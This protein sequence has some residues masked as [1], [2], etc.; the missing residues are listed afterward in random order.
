M[1]IALRSGGFPYSEFTY[2]H[3]HFA[4]FVDLKPENV[5]ICIDDVESIIKA[6]LAASSS[7]SPPTKLVG[8][9]PSKG[10]G[11][12]QTPRSESVSIHSSQPLPS[13]SSSFGSSPMLDKWAFSM[14]KI[15]G[16]GGEGSI[17]GSVGSGGRDS[18]GEIKER[19][20]GGIDEA[21]EKLSS[22]SFDS[23]EFDRKGKM[24]NANAPGPSLLTQMAPPHSTQ[25]STTESG[26]TASV[27]TTDTTPATS[28]APLSTSAM[29]V[30]S[31]G[32]SMGDNASTSS[33]IE[34]TERITVKIADLGNGS[35]AFP[36][37]VFI[38]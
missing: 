8:V 26:T 15:E 11:G 29:S 37:M 32:R 33:V 34:G 14:S 12:N 7:T 3:K 6:E 24:Q 17:P 5:L 9:P 16:K 2:S 27:T 28:E 36:L 4:A 1:K 30:D 35:F 25:S 20:E 19:K 23:N 21:E 22:M 18:R 31:T 10:R 38:Y 13:P